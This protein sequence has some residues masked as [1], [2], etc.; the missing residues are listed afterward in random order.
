AIRTSSTI[1]AHAG[2][3]SKN[4]AK[5][6]KNF[7]SDDVSFPAQIANRPRQKKLPNFGRID[8][9]VL[10]SRTKN[11]RISRAIILKFYCV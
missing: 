9:K 2:T 10:K 4:T 3:A 8:E 6:L 1:P 5:Y 11:C 7:M